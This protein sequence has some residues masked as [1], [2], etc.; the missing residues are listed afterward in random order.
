VTTLTPDQL[1]QLVRYWAIG[2]P[3][4]EAAAQL[5][6]EHRRWLERADFVAACVDRAGRTA[7][8][9]WS[10]VPSFVQD[11]ACSSSEARLLRLAAEL[12]AIDTGVP[13]A[14]LVAGLDDRNSRTVARAI[15]HALRLGARR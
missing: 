14:E 8:V 1:A 4:S 13:L 7:P 15:A 12:A 9:R 3:A 10:A 5:L 2:D 6:C 11:A